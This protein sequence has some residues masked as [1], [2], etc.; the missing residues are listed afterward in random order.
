MLE[1]EE[2][3]LSP[4]EKVDNVLKCAKCGGEY[5]IKNGITVMRESGFGGRYVTE[6]YLN[7]YCDAPFS[8]YIELPSFDDTFAPCGSRLTKSNRRGG[9]NIWKL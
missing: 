6:W 1:T 7:I 5:G 3:W 8:K 9:D 4:L 2:L